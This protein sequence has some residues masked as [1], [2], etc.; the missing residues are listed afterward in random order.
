VLQAEL[1]VTVLGPP[2]VL[3]DVVAHVLGS[4][5]QAAATPTEETGPRHLP[6]LTV[7]VDPTFA[8]WEAAKASPTRILL[9]TTRALED[10]AVMEAVVRGADAVLHADSPPDEM[11]RAATVVADGGTALTPARVRA[12]AEMVRSCERPGHGLVQRLTRREVEILASIDRGES[13]KQTARAIGI[14]T[15]TVENL[16]TRLFRKLG[17]R[18]RAQAIMRAHSAGLVSSAHDS[19]PR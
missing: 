9:F 19:V 2:G 3:R 10:E 4:G 12:L 8:D 17:V 5:G 15:K 1:S 6:A 7:L 18:N 11:V 16:Q 14:S 13:V